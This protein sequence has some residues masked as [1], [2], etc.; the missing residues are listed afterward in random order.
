M[1]ICKIEGCNNKYKGKGYC[2]KHLTRFRQYGNSLCGIEESN[3]LYPNNVTDFELGYV[4]G[5]FEGEGNISCREF[6]GIMHN[7]PMALKRHAQI[8]ISNTKLEL[9]EKVQEILKIGKVIKLKKRENYKQLYIWRLIKKREMFR[10]L[11]L[12]RKYLL[13][14]KGKAELLIAYLESREKNY[15]NR[16]TEKEADFFRKCCQLKSYNKNQSRNVDQ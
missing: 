14:H 2:Q 3:I 7:N 11:K 10:F 6:R 5:L 13:V 15:W 1:K 16:H 12:I 9:L 4:I 8:T